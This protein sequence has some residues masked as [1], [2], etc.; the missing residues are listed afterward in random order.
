MNNLIKNILKSRKEYYENKNQFKVL[1][2][3]REQRIVPI[4]REMYNKL[5]VDEYLI[6]DLEWLQEV[7]YR[8]NNWFKFYIIRSKNIYFNTIKKLIK[9]YSLILKYINILPYDIKMLILNKIIYPKNSIIY[10]CHMKI[11]KNE[12]IY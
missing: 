11:I 8:T 5:K 4:Y 12:F 2:R 10:H 9:S 1:Y 7:N 6:I 3:Y